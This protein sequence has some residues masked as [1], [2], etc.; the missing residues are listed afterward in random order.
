MSNSQKS[1]R[2]NVEPAIVH[3]FMEE[4][5]RFNKLLE[6]RLVGI[7]ADGSTRVRIPFKDEF[8]GDP[9]KR[10]VHGGVIASLIDV[11]GGAT[12]FASFLPDLSRMQ[13]LNTV[14]MRVDYLRGGTGE[15]FEAVG[16]VIRKGNRIV[17]THILVHNDAGDRIAMG[18]A[19]YS[20][21]QVKAPLPQD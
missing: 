19:T 15:W 8:I 4:M 1:D 21:H 18:T 20:V 14:D 12:A 9:M 3:K 2:T 10:I 11:T 7:E 5:V 16:Q 6:L 17:V 13:G